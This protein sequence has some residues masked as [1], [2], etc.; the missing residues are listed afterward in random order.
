[1]DHKKDFFIIFVQYQTGIDQ[2]LFS[3]RPSLFRQRI[4]NG[5][6]ILNKER[7]N[8]VRL[9]CCRKLKCKPENKKTNVDGSSET[10]HVCYT[11]ARS[12]SASP[13]VR[14]LSF[15]NGMHISWTACSSG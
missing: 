4:L 15:P 14:S 9:I 6:R 12:S 2:N 3:L 10:E 8:S 13:G 5:S 7:K 11:I 1:M